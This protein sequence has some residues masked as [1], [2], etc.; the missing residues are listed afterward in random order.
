MIV[1][2]LAT[3]PR[4]MTDLESYLSRSLALGLLTL[5]LFC[6]LLTGAMP[7][8][9]GINEIKAEDPDST[10]IKDPYAYPALIVTTIYH[11]LS[12][13]YLYTQI[14]GVAGFT[15]GFGAG[16]VASTGLFCMGIW[17][18]LFGS[19]KGRIS[20]TTGADK[21][22]SNFPFENRESAREK[23]KESKRKSV[24]SKLR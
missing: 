24:S 16:M 3:A 8:T 21:R 17:V 20:K 5:A 12:A 14:A 11:A 18:L 1:S 6:L 15:F 2:L 22:T 7:L 9:T 13:F 23:K 4:A 10:T 19:E